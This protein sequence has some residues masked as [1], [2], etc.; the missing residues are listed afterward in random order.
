[1]E[2]LVRAKKRLA[3]NLRLEKGDDAELLRR[4][5]PAIGSH[6]NLLSRRRVS[7]AC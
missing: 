6:T 5:A 4:Y 2:L 3:P 1:M 7:D